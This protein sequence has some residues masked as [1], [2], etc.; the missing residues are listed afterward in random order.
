MEHDVALEIRREMEFVFVRTV[1]EALDAAF[2]KNTLGW[3]S[4]TILVESRL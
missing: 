1:K 4:E 2:G 3:R